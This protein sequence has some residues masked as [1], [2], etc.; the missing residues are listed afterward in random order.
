MINRFRLQNFRCFGAAVDVPLKP[1][2]VL[3]GQNDSGKSAFVDA[4]YAA[5]RNG[6]IGKTDSWRT[7]TAP[8][9]DVFIGGGHFRSAFNHQGKLLE[10]KR[11][12]GLEPV[13]LYRLP[14]IGIT[15]SSKGMPEKLGEPPQLDLQGANLAGVLDYVLRQD[16]KRFQEIVSALAERVHGLVDVRIRT[17]NAEAREIDFVFEEGLLL[18]ANA[19]STGVR[20]ILFFITLV[21]LAYPPQL[22]LVE[23]PETG[24][25]P[26]R[27][28]D[29]VGLLRD[30]TTGKYGKHKAQVVL[31]T[32]SPYLLDQINLETDQVLVFRIQEDGTRTVQPVDE[33]RLSKFLDEFMLGEVWYN[34]GESGL[35]TTE[36]NA[37]T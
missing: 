6:G 28:S 25:H 20:V 7:E 18:P 26:R 17:P 36:R 2:T 12:E 15:M 10:H 8:S 29:I 30:L 11:V 34:R 32:H 21:H 3:I 35:V 19:A 4:V 24:V 33:E 13:G 37:E 31:T 23:E 1:L 9:W 16:R 5:S 27:L 14:S 22:V